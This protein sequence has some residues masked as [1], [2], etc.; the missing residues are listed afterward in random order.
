LRDL[1]CGIRASKNIK[2]QVT[3]L[4]Q[5]IDEEFWQLGGKT[6]GM[7][8]LANRFAAREILA[9]GFGI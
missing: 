5:Q 8:F 1:P 9:V 2:R 6:G 4:S 3:R 7:L